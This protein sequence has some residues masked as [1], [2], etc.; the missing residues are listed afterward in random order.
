M[1]PLIGASGA[2]A[3]VLG[4]Y[5]V[6]Y[7]RAKVWSLL[8]FLFFIPVRIPAWLV[9]GGWSCSGCTRPAMPPWTQAPWPTSRTSSASWPSSRQEP[10]R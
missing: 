10:R 4:A 9:L 1:Q 8:P 5:L 6:I 7:P 2:I 3:G